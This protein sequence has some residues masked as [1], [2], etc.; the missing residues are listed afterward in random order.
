MPSRAVPRFYF[1]LHQGHVVRDPEGVELS[2]LDAAI[3]EAFRILPVIAAD[4]IPKGDDRQGFSIIVRDGD[5]T[6]LYT[7]ALSF[8]GTRL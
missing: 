6:P 7:A 3:R 1:D 5:R 2:D 8:C 4:A